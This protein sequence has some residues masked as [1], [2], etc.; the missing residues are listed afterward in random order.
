MRSTPLLQ[1]TRRRTDHA[2]QRTTLVQA[3]HTSARLNQ[4]SERRHIP[5]C[6]YNIRI[7]APAGWKR[8][9]GADLFGWEDLLQYRRL[10]EQL[11]PLGEAQ[12]WETEPVVEMV[13]LQILKQTRGIQKGRARVKEQSEWRLKVVFFVPKVTLQASVYTHSKGQQNESAED[14]G[15]FQR[16][17]RLYSV[18]YLQSKKENAE[19]IRWQ[20]L[21]NQMWILIGVENSPNF[22]LFGFFIQQSLFIGGLKG[23]QCVG[24]VQRAK[25]W[26]AADRSGSISGGITALWL[27]IL[28]SE[29]CACVAR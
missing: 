10:P 7:T 25:S 11:N 21:P 19:L 17:A 9:C 14:G 2:A 26:T 5:V 8:S 16:R 3:V 22:Y 18:P 23:V 28:L 27:C 1:P 29:L 12:R 13:L 6:V 24:V 20:T 4:R 15:I